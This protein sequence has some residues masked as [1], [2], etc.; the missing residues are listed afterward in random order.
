MHVLVGY[1]PSERRFLARV[2]YVSRV[3]D[4]K[5]SVEGLPSP[6]LVGPPYSSPL[7]V[8]TLEPVGARAAL[9]SFQ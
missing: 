3:R 7:L 4:L 8:N 9:E 2:F 1:R 6:D 5:I